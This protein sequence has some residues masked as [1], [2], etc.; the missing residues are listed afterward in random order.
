MI[1]EGDFDEEFEEP[2][3]PEIPEDKIE[4]LYSLAEWYPI[5]RPWELM[6]DFH[7]IVIVDPKSGDRQLAVV[8]GNAGTVFAIHLY[9]PEEGTRWYSMI[10]LEGSTPLSSHLA[11]YDNRYLEIEWTNGADLDDH[12]AYLDDIFCPD[13][14]MEEDDPTALNAVQFRQVKPG[15]P[16]WHPDLDS[17]DRMTDA[18][19][20]VRHY[21]ENHFKEY[22]WAS[23]TIDLEE[24][25]VELPTFSLPPRARRDNPKSWNFSM[26]RFDVPGAKEIPEILPDDLFVT[27]LEKFKV[28]PGTTWELGAIFGPQPIVANGIP[29]Y[30][31]IAFVADHQ[32]GRAEGSNLMPALAPRETLLRTTLQKAAESTGHLPEEILVGSPIAELA[33]AD[34]CRKKKIKITPSENLPMFNEMAEDLMNSRLF[35]SDDVEGFA[36]NLSPGEISF[37]DAEK[38][39][40]VIRQMPENP[41]PEEAAA[42]IQKLCELPAANGLMD[43]ILG[44]AGLLKEQE[45]HPSKREDDLFPDN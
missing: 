17:V 23:F 18:L 11:Q 7:A 30:P 1:S 44:K 35:R 22:E 27:R 13:S 36:E 34:L 21:Y 8:M 39:Q 45:D 32:T 28:Q 12:D 43:A 25:A 14:W 40:E 33:L 9:Q 29:S 19:L 6:F 2:D 42:W 24:M 10:Q 41:S 3:I 26:E 38:I 16:P 20:L 37:E 31:T 4:T 5:A 15:C